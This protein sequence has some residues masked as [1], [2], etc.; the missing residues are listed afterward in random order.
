[1][2]DNR[3]SLKMKFSHPIT[4]YNENHVLEKMKLREF[5]NEDELR[6]ELIPEVIYD[7]LIKGTIP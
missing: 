6:N 2:N 4:L 5:A 3:E 1:M 7:Y